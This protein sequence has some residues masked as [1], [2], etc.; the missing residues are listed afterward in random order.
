VYGFLKL[1]VLLL[2]AAA[3]AAVSTIYLLRFKQAAAPASPA[4]VPY[5]VL[6]VQGSI[7]WTGGPSVQPARLPNA[8]VPGLWRSFQT[9]EDGSSLLVVSQVS[10]RDGLY[11]VRSFGRRAAQLQPPPRTYGPGPWRVAGTTWIG[12]TDVAAL[13][14]A[15]GAQETNVVARYS[16]DEA[17]P[18]VEQWLRA[19]P[20][21]G[22]AVALSPDG[23][24]IARVQA[25]PAV[26]GFAGQVQVRLRQVSGARSSVALRYLGSAVP[27]AVLWSSDGGT[28]A[29][30][31][32]GQGLS[33]QKSSGR[34]V[35]QTSSGELPAAFSPKG[36][37]LAFA[38]GS[39]GSLRLHVLNLHGEVENVLA[40]P[41]SGSLQ[42]LGWTPDAR[43]LVCVLGTTLYQVDPATGA[44]QKLP[45]TMPGIL[46]GAV[47]ATSP[48][49]H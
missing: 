38:G 13:W 45:G 30:E 42:A 12:T 17:V 18:H 27:S 36:A 29:I 21:A 3:I 19:P 26:N 2:I 8:G 49:V 46:M 24:Q 41:G 28:L 43:A 16:V 34:P 25:L 44:A 33:I 14:S 31:V 5:R 6:L 4:P 22:R 10:G 9:A 47:P 11:L 23:S 37:A 32:P 40:S 7:V 1:A 48:L 35:H 39:K 15:G 20:A